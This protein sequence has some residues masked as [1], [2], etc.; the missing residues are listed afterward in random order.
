[1]R[2]IKVFSGG[3][4]HR[5]IAEPLLPPD[6]EWIEVKVPLRDVFDLYRRHE[7][8]A[9]IASG[10]PLFYGLAATLQREFPD[11]R[12]EVF[13]APN[14]LQSLARALAIPYGGMKCVSATGRPYAEMDAALIEGEA[15]IG[16]LTDRTHTPDDI[17]R[18]MI[19]YG[20]TNYSMAI[21]E[22]LGNEERERCRRMSLAEA[23]RLSFE[24]PN[25]VILQRDARRSRPFGIA[26]S[27]MEG[28]PGRP[29]MITKMPVRLLSLAMLGLDDRTS[30]WDIGYC[31]GSVSIEARLRFPRLKITSFEVR[32]ECAGILERNAA[33][34]GA[35]GIDAH[36]GDFLT[37]PLDELPRPDAVF[38]GGHG[39]KLPEML[40]RL[41]P[42]LLP[43]AAVVFNSVSEQS[44]ALFEQAV[45]RQ[46]LAITARHRMALDDFNPITV[47]KAE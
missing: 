6:A 46:G 24:A 47:L 25:C 14:S 40:A 42:L 44:L 5:E 26:E 8:I 32:P 13:P 35:P 22:N 19:R 16:V 2:G 33:R 37:L 38:I 43:G 1:M 29:R 9:V 28:L 12:I 30:L 15:L 36:T 10:D 34:F 4:R 45:A 20:F 27:D 11:A 23:S 31:T 21:G 17:A 18:R 7:E 41:K 3:R 39:G